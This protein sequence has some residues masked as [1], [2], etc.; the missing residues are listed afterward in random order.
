MRSDNLVRLQRALEDAGVMFL[1]EGDV[2]PGGAGVRL[3]RRDKMPRRGTGQPT[4]PW[5]LR[6]AVDKD[7]LLTVHAY[8]SSRDLCGSAAVSGVI[9]RFVQN[10]TLVP[11]VQPDDCIGWD[12]CPSP[13]GIGATGLRRKWPFREVE[14]ERKFDLAARS[15]SAPSSIDAFSRFPRGRLWPPQDY[16][17]GAGSGRGC[18]L[19]PSIRVTGGFRIT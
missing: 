3:R 13:R 12:S 19:L 6:G 18:T 10:R 1:D 7:A 14:G 16:P 4:A 5:S 17:S 8:A 11:A 2:R 15:S 9:A